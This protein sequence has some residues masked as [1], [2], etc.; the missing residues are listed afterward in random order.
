MRS[1]LC[2]QHAGSRFDR[3][4]N[5][6]CPRGAV[7]IRGG[8]NIARATL[9]TMITLTEIQKIPLGLTGVYRIIC[10]SNGKN[11]VGATKC[12]KR[13]WREHRRDLRLGTHHNKRLQFAWNEYGESAFD[14]VLIEKCLPQNYTSLEQEHM[15]AL[16]ACDPMFGF[17]VEPIAR[18]T[19][20]GV[21]HTPETCE[22][23]SS[24]LS[25]YYS[26]PENRKNASDARNAAFAANPE[27]MAK[28]RKP[29]LQFTKDGTFIS[30]HDS[31]KAA[32]LVFRVNYCSIASSIRK[33][34]T[35]CGFKWKFE[36]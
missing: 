9:Q 4:Q 26:N 33:N 20:V 10:L 32:A 34:G 16:R 13:R 27:L 5:N 30:R 14:F 7:L 25:R 18:H 31:L 29:V 3:F 15:N 24:A 22:K 21:I 28:H 23:H 11:Y 36:S 8:S 6:L 17:N 12:I 35:S 2:Q 1:T 19:S